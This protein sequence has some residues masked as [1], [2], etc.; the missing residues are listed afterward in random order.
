M[1]EMTLGE[2][3]E[4]LEHLDCA[5]KILHGAEGEKIKSPLQETIKVA[6]KELSTVS[7]EKSEVEECTK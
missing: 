1:Q 5:Y 3:I 2:M 6:C 4:V 7:F